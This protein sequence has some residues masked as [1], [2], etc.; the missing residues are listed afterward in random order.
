MPTGSFIA[1]LAAVSAVSAASLS[2]VVALAPSASAG[3]PAPAASYFSRINH[4]RAV[5][6]LRP[7]TMR[8]D[9]NYVAQRWANRMASANRLSHNPSL[10]SQ[11]PNWQ[12]VGEN[13]GEG[14]TIAALDTAFWN[15]PEHRSNILDRS[16]TDVGIGT[17]RAANGILWITVDFR[18]PM[19]AESS[20]TIVRPTTTT[21]TPR[22]AHRT[23]RVGMRGSDVALVQRK[24][25]VTA[26]GI[27][28]PRTKR[29]V[30]RFQ[31]AHHLA[32]T[33]VVGAATWRALH[34]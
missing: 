20:S 28:G 24:L 4:E 21:Q 25:H 32:A 33:G 5:H 17:T 12:T 3:V 18:R 9:L 16:Y 13:V 30:V 14:P 15:S 34:V 27:F 26:D 6:G 19:R 23:L 11:V 22:L 29:A 2:G 7:L 8:S 31:R 1:R 10:T